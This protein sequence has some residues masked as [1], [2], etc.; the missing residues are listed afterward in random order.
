MPQRALVGLR[1]FLN[2][3][4]APAN[5]QEP[6]SFVSRQPALSRL[7]SFRENHTHNAAVISFFR[8]MID[9]RAQ[10]F[11]VALRSST[12]ATI[13]AGAFVASLAVS[14]RSIFTTERAGDLVEPPMSE[15]IQEPIAPL[16]SLLRTGMAWRDVIQID[17]DHICNANLRQTALSPCRRVFRGDVARESPFSFLALSRAASSANL[18]AC[19]LDEPSCGLDDGSRAIS[20]GRS[21]P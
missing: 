15:K 9:C 6:R 14:V 5:P 2:L 4:S 19:V 11:E 8:M 20:T 18:S 1:A 13:A 10:I 12:L 21:Q 7:A 16:G 17:F 3:A